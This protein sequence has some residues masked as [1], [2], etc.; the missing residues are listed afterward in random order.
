LIAVRAS[1]I[2]IA[3]GAGQFAIPPESFFADHHESG[4]MAL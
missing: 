2:H 4:A 1:S 3:A